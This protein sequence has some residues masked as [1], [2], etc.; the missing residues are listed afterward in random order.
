M[1]PASSSL[2]SRNRLA[3]TSRSLNGATRIS[4]RRLLGIPAESGIGCG[5]LP[6]RRQAHQRIV[7]HAVKAALEFEDLVALAKRPSGA[8]RIEVRL[9]AGG[10]EAHL[11]GAGHGLDDGLGEL[12]PPAVVGEEGR[13]LGNALVDGGGDLGMGVANE[14]RARAEQ[15][16]DILPAA[17]VP[18]PAAAALAD[19]HLGREIAESAAGQHAL[20]LIDKPALDLALAHRVHRIA[21]AIVPRQLSRPT[22]PRVK[23]FPVLSVYRRAPFSLRGAMT[24]IEIWRAA[25]LMLRWYGATAE[26][27]SARRAD[28]LVGAGDPAGAADW[29]RIIEGIGQ[30]ANRTP[31]GPLH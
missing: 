23:A 17:L 22:R 27:E 29:R 15:E 5:K 28:E 20:G 2:C 13:A 11:L 21:S 6:L 4:S 9:G 1:T 10:D 24:E 18:H 3:T 30:L 19:H 26:Q 12:D 7:A 25:Y 31:P 16:I 8:H 14:H